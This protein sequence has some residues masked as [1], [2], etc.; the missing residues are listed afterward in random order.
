MQIWGRCSVDSCPEIPSKSHRRPCPVSVEQRHNLPRQRFPVAVFR[1][2]L[3]T[4]HAKW[5]QVETD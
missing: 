5:E 3:L 4:C 2:A 1:V